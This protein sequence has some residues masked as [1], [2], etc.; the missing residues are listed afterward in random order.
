MG[1][2]RFG[3]IPMRSSLSLSVS[4]LFSSSD[5][6]IWLLLGK[7]RAKEILSVSWCCHAKRNVPWICSFFNVYQ[8]GVR[9]NLLQSDEYGINPF[10]V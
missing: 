5:V 6:L 4:G 7:R 8:F 10:R 1:L 9:P 3:L 2:L